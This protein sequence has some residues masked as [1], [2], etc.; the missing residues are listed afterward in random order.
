M[1][2]SWLMDTIMDPMQFFRISAESVSLQSD[3]TGLSW[4]GSLG[5]TS[6]LFHPHNAWHEAGS[7]LKKA[8]FAAQRPEK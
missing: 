6:M 5:S 1:D 4:F 3:K 2:F 7:A 8:S